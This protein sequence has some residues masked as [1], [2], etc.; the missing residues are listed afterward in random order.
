MITSALPTWILH[1]RWV[2][3]TS[4]QI[5]FLTEEEG[6]LQALYRG[7]RS[8]KKKPLIQEFMP[9]WVSLNKRGEHVYV[10]QLEA[11]APS[12][13]LK[14]HALFAALYTNELLCLLLHPSSELNRELFALYTSTLYAL[15]KASQRLQIEAILRC[16]E[17]KFL[18]LSG[19]Q[20]SLEHDNAMRPIVADKR[21]NFLAGSGFFAE[22]EGISGEHILAFAQNKF[23]DAATLKSIKWFMRQAI[24]YA[25]DGKPLRTRKLYLNSPS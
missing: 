25:L 8:L 4:V 10:Q 24:D 20:V 12:L 22:K 14:G 13:Q 15:A 21:Y 9:L 2:R 5:T 7:G 19:Y 23:N 18:S 3:D 11:S 6:L 16:F 1:K 17:W